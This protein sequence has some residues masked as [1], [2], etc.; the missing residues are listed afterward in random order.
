[1][2]LAMVSILPAGDLVLP[3]SEAVVL[4]TVWAAVLPEDAVEH[5]SVRVLQCEI[6][7]GVFAVTVDAEWLRAV[8]LNLVT[9][10][11][12]MS[13][14]LRDGIVGRHRNVANLNL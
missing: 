11:C 10:A 13:P 8:A 9:R 12:R 5:L 7:V 3:V 14:L 1:M 2:R 6:V 4:D